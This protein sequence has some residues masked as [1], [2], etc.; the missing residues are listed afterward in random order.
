MYLLS[1]FHAKPSPQQS[2]VPPFYRQLRYK[3]SDKIPDF[4]IASLLFDFLFIYLFFFLVF[5]F[6]F[7]VYFFNCRHSKGYAVDPSF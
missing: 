1:H 4:S 2:S 3:L 6:F 5:F 7:L